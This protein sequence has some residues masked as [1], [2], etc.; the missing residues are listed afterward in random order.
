MPVK[1]KLSEAIRAGCKDSRQV[2]DVFFEGP[3]GRDTLAAA[4]VGS[5]FPSLAY[6]H[7]F[8]EA[9][10]TELGKSANCPECGALCN[11]EVILGHLNDVHRMPRENIADW[12]ESRGQ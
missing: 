11:L 1:V 2:H 10:K 5:G 8:R 6:I 7:D 12:L 3:D 4:M 9:Y